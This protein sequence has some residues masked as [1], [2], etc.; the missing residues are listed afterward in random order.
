MLIFLIQLFVC[1]RALLVKSG[2]IVHSVE[3]EVHSS[4]EQ[5]RENV[6]G[7]GYLAVVGFALDLDCLE[8]QARGFSRGRI[9][10]QFTKPIVVRL[11]LITISHRKKRQTQSPLGGREAWVGSRSLLKFRER[12]I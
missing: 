9:S 6:L 7:C 12:A 5:I 2:T 3:R 10:V 4:I 11:S 8:M 1:L